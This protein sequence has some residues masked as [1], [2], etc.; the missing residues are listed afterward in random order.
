MASHVTQHLGQEVQVPH[1]V[2]LGSPWAQR[3]IWNLAKAEQTSLF[4]WQ[5]YK[6]SNIC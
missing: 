1:M 5:L 3:H 4:T 6:V 2:M